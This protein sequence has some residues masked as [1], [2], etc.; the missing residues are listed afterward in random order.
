M[1]DYISYNDEII[2]F[3]N[4]N[5]YD[6]VSYE[7]YLDDE[8]IGKSVDTFFRIKNLSPDHSYSVLIK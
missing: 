7:I 6:T 3:W 2:L 1:F 4:T 5:N 8:K